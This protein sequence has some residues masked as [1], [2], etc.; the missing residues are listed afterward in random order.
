M[1]QIRSA[2]NG[3]VQAA[4]DE[5]VSNGSQIGIQVAAYLDGELVIDAWSG[6]ADE[7]TGRAV[8]GETLFNVYSVTKAVAATALHLQA[9]RGLIDYDAPIAQYWPEFAANGKSLA[10]P[11]HALTHRVGVP[12]MP[13]GVNVDRMCDWEWMTSHIADAEPLFEPGTRTAYQSMTFGWIIGELVRRTDPAQRSLGR[14]VREEIAEP[15]GITDLW[16]GIPDEV[17]SRIARLRIDTVPIPPEHLPPLF[18]AS[19]PDSVGLVPSVFEVPQVRR[20]DIPGVGGIFNARSEARFFAMLAQCGELDGVRL[21][22]EGLA[23]ALNTPRVDADEPDPVMFGSLVQ[24]EMSL[25][26]GLDSN[27]K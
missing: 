11:R 14:Y 20:A 7:S 21:L 25:K 26:R 13:E 17:E 24:R 10:T 15:L 27:V 18:T 8:D 5:A 4:L 9:D 23:R 19:M 2:S 16:I 12:Q 22:S 3:Q 6:V 1:T